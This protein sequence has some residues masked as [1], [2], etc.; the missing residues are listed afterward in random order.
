MKMLNPDIEHHNFSAIKRFTIKPGS[1]LDIPKVVM[2]G[3]RNFE[4]DLNEYFRKQ[5]NDTELLLGMLQIYK[6]Y[7]RDGAVD[8]V[9]SKQRYVK[10]RHEKV[11]MELIKENMCH[12]DQIDMYFKH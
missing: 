8:I 1:I 10:R 9:S 6:I 4:E 12:L 2:V 7:K 11:V 3:T 5:I